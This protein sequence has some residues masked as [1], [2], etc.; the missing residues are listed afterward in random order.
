MQAR[1][2]FTLSENHIWPS[3]KM[4]I[5]SATVESIDSL[6][7]WTFLLVQL[8]QCGSKFVQWCNLLTSQLFARNDKESSTRLVDLRLCV[9]CLSAFFDLLK[10]HCHYG[11][12]ILLLKS[13]P[14]FSKWPKLAGVATHSRKSFQTLA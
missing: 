10:S 12:V 1:L 13:G 8:L 2:D 9:P 7:K 14:T 6:A 11:F 4:W 5:H 3:Q